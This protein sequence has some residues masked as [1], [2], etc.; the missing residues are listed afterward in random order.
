ML[1]RR[2]FHALADL[3]FP[4]RC[5]VCHAPAL[6]RD[7]FCEHCKG[8]LFADPHLA[9]PRCAATVG[10]YS[11]Q[12]DQCASC[13]DH[14]PAFDA[15]VRLG[16]YAGAVEE[17]VLRMK[18]AFHEGLAERLGRRLA[19]LH[20]PRLLQMSLAAVVPV[21]LHWRKRLWRGYNQS[22]SLALGLGRQLGVP[23]RPLWLARVKPTPEQRGMPSAAARR[24]NVRGAFRA[25]RRLDG[26]RLLL[27]DDVMTTGATADEAARALKKA[28]AVWVGVAALARA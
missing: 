23:V 3:V 12:D 27:V 20:R 8:E 10:P 13:R 18:N 25:R 21:P 16:A 28:G 4:P 9:C 2:V 1:A 11:L 19:E 14:P 15:A 5:L 26:L 24:E 6:D 22:A 7:H 17:A